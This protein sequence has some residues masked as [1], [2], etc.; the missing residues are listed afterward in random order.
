[1]IADLFRL[2]FIAKKKNNNDFCFQNLT[3]L[4]NNNVG[5]LLIN[6]VIIVYGNIVLPKFPD[7]QVCIIIQQVPDRDPVY[8]Q[9]NLFEILLN[10]TEIRL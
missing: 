5:T 2:S 10:R 3:K 1:M 4:N 6:I 8:T 7:T 9:R